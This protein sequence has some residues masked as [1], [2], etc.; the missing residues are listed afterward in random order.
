MRYERTQ[1]DTQGSE[2]D[3]LE[4]SGTVRDGFQEETTSYS[5]KIFGHLF[6]VLLNSPLG[7]KMDE[8]TNLIVIFTSPGLVASPTTLHS[9]SLIRENFG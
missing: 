9:F 4:P 1:V 5:F 8:G 3:V 6:Q 7:G 2:R